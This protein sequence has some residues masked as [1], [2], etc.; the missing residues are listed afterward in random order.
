MEIVFHFVQD[1]MSFTTV[2]HAFARKIFTELTE[3]V[4]NVQKE[5]SMILPLVIVDHYVGLTVFIA[6]EDAIVMQVFMSLTIVANSVPLVL[7]TTI[8]QNHV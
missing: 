1:L 6:E 4:K 5:V 2:E 8:K 3:F 7:D